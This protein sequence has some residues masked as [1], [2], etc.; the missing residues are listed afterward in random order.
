MVADVR[1]VV[2][3]DRGGSV[4]VVVG[5]ETLQCRLIRRRH[6]VAVS[7]ACVVGVGRSVSA[8]I[9]DFCQQY[10]ERCD[11]TRRESV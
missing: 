1:Q 5:S 2:R 11:A 10:L 3:S 8:A 6:L 9:A 7:A 4:A